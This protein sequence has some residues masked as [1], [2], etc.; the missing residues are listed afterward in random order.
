MN[1]CSLNLNGTGGK[2]LSWTQIL[3]PSQVHSTNARCSHMVS[4]WPHWGNADQLGTRAL[5]QVGRALLTCDQNSPGTAS[6]QVHCCV[7]QTAWPLG[8]KSIGKLRHLVGREKEDDFPQR[9][10][11]LSQ[12]SIPPTCVSSDSLDVWVFM[13]SAVVVHSIQTDL[14]K[15]L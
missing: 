12:F 11:V 5:G 8:K 4:T 6:A 2:G 3:F 13:M 15:G 14:R 7:H 9:R 1:R 10:L